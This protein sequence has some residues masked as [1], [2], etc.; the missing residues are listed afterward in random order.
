MTD[1]PDETAPPKVDP[2]RTA[3]VGGDDTRTNIQ[4]I[5]NAGPRDPGAG[6]RIG[7]IVDSRYE[8]VG[9]LG[10]GGMASVHRLR[11]REWGVELAVKSPHWQ[12]AVNRAFQD[13]FVREALAWIELGAHP[14]IVQCLYVETLENLPRIFMEIVS[15]G[16]LSDWLH[17]G[18]LAVGDWAHITDL[19]IQACD[20]L[21]HAHRRGLVHRDVKPSNFL[22]GDDGRLRISDFGLVK[23]KGI[24]DVKDAGGA[25]IRPTGAN[26][27]QVGAVMGTFSYSAPEQLGAAEAV[28]ARADIYALGVTLFEL[29]CGRRPF[30]DMDPEDEIEEYI[31]DLKIMR[32]PDPRDLNPKI[33]EALATLITRCLEKNRNDRPGDVMGVRAV[34]GEVHSWISGRAIY[35]VPPVPSDLR[36]AGSNNRGVSLWNLDLK[37]EAEKSWEEALRIDPLHAEARVNLGFLQWRDGRVTD[38]TLARQ[39]EACAGAQPTGHLYLAQVH[40]ARGAHHE[41]EKSLDAFLAQRPADPVALALRIEAALGQGR[42]DR[43]RTVLAELRAAGGF[44][45]RKHEERIA[46]AEKSRWAAQDNPWNRYLGPLPQVPV[47]LRGFLP[48]EAG[49]GIFLLDERGDVHHSE[50]AGKP[51]RVIGRVRLDESSGSAPPVEMRATASAL[52]VLESPGRVAV[53]S[54]GRPGPVRYLG[55]PGDPVVLFRTTPDQRR[56]IT[57]SRSGT[58]VLWDLATGKPVAST[59]AHLAP[60]TA[61]E[62]SRDG[63]HIYSGDATGRIRALEAS[64]GKVILELAAHPGRVVTLLTN[65]ERGMFVSAGEDREIRKWSLTDGSLGLRLAGHTDRLAGLA[66]LPSRRFIVSVGADGTLRLWNLFIGQCLRTFADAG[67]PLVAVHAGNDPHQVL[68]LDQGGVLHAFHVEPPPLTPTFSPRVNRVHDHGESR[69]LQRDFE[70]LLDQ[71][72]C[73]YQMGNAPD[74]YRSIVEA[75]RIPGYQ[76]DTRAMDLLRRLGAELPRRG[77][78]LLRHI[79]PMSGHEA[80][81]TSLRPGPAGAPWISLDATGRILLWDVPEITSR[82]LPGEGIAAVAAF[83]RYR[84]GEGVVLGTGEGLVL[85]R[86]LP[87]G[88]DLEICGAEAPVSALSMAPYRDEVLVGLADGRLGSEPLGAGAASRALRGPGPAIRDLRHDARGLRAASLDVEGTLTVWDLESGRALPAPD[89]AAGPVSAFAFHPT[90]PSLLVARAGGRLARYR[91]GAPEESQEGGAGVAP[92]VAIEITADGRF[93]LELDAAGVLT[94]IEVVSGR[95]LHRHELENGPAVC[96]MAMPAGE[97]HLMVSRG[98]TSHLYEIDWELDPETPRKTTPSG[99]MDMLARAR[100]LK[101]GA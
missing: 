21:S 7:E 95:R 55:V 8:V 18:R 32:A 20:G 91:P 38:D 44:D 30:D 34:L 10:E 28:D 53:L 68:A 9:F 84:G 79:G 13:R 22:V 39:L 57:G 86:R 94:L 11:H 61:L 24:A 27:T 66:A 47:R 83:D 33:P 43:A 65:L 4:A 77:I 81:V 45:L 5:G 19:M 37:A 88:A 89:A 76:R 97:H 40:L 92:V 72:T 59:R 99:V 71:A 67:V 1:Q 2:T 101:S 70:H 52:F 62:V 75:R 82:P 50:A 51:G 63:A 35:L 90:E 14:N 48:V 26:L 31:D 100:R 17:Q 54:P 78:G 3:L 12:W 15:G 56:L 16:S 74:S 6:W 25:P 98:G 87:S 49:P 73:Q 80:P 29:A 42:P 36:A 60:I 69:R 96:A 64:T 41:C 93:A 85:L 58:L 23:M 46:A